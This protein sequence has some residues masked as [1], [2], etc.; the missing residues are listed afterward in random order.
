MKRA[1]F[2]G[3]IGCGKTTLLQRLNRLTIHYN[4][5]QS[6]EFFKNIIDTPG[7]F[8]EH[9]RMYT[10]IATTA[11]DADVVVLLQSATDQRLIFPEAFSTMFGRPVVGVVT[12]IDLA[13]TLDQLKWAEK[14]LREAG[15]QRIFEVSAL[16]G[17]QL[18]EFQAYLEEK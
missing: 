3:A 12:K 17:L 14:Q 7:E 1:M 5:T 6:V 15:A 10:N 13:T 11:M 8:I 18:D 2:V 16:K 9:R 4:K